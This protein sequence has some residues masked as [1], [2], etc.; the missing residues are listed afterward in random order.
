MHVNQA[1]I[2]VGGKGTR[3]GELAQAT[4]KPLLEVAP[5]V[6]F[7]DVV[8]GEF[9]R[10]GF[11]DILML[12]GHRS[13]Q[14]KTAYHG[15]DV[16]GARI[17]VIA[18]P[19]PQGTGGALRFAQAS[20]APRFVL[21][22]GDSLFEI[23]L[24]A[25]T[26]P[27]LT[28]VARLALRSVPD[29]SRYGAV[30]LD[31]PSIRAFR[32]KDATRS[33][34]AV[35]NGGIYFIN[36]DILDR[37][38]GPCSIETDIFP[39]LASEGLLEG[40]IF[41][42]YFLDMGLPETYE[43]ARSEVAQRIRKPCVFLDRDGVINIDEGYTHRADQLQWIPGAP[44][45]IRRLNEAGCYV[46]VVSNQAGVAR[47]YYS[48]ADV[49]AFHAEMSRRL[50]EQGAHIDAFYFC[51]FHPDGVIGTYRDPNHPDRKPN[52]GMIRRALQDWPID[53]DRSCLIGDRA[54]DLEAA[55]AAGVRGILFESG[56]LDQLVEAA[57]ADIGAQ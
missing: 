19:E 40:R 17:R 14:V 16:H 53:Q 31:G 56:R 33:G 37:I 21:C 42:G 28:G 7:V 43:R 34:P 24:R 8:I 38:R 22:N 45:A 13:D 57:I 36:R 12:A 55:A 30:D 9:A 11:T 51:P 26:S 35:I 41:D 47:G 32:E 3:L 1:V 49:E 5:G 54:T 6:R 44:E 18:E 15:R 23:N 27:P 4:P 46:I 29:A 50:A 39:V 2:L 10:H 25:L 20:L 52:P 48:E